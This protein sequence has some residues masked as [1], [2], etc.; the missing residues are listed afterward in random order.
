MHTTPSLDDIAN[1]LGEVGLSLMLP[2]LH[3]WLSRFKGLE[4]YMAPAMHPLNAVYRSLL[5]MT[6]PPYTCEELAQR[7]SVLDFLTLRAKLADQPGV[8]WDS[9]MESFLDFCC[10]GKIEVWQSDQEYPAPEATQA[11]LLANIPIFHP[12]A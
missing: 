8:R 3:R 4:E 10:K 11:W 12:Q 2:V 7:L 1:R 5:G 6:D 9:R